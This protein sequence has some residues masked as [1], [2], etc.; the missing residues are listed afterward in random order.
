[1]YFLPLQC[2]C[3]ADETDTNG[4][5]SA[6]VWRG[7]RLSAVCSRRSTLPFLK[8]LLITLVVQSAE[9]LL[10]KMVAIN[11]SSPSPPLSLLPSLKGVD[12]NK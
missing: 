6:S 3:T 10:F 8:G 9:L 1:M 12:G 11:A 4:V 2:L 5:A 7:R